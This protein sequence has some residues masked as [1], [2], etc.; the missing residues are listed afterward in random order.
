MR[1]VV[2]C[3]ALLFGGCVQSGLVPCESKAC[4]T[5]KVCAT[6]DAEPTCVYPEQ[7][8]DCTGKADGEPCTIR[9]TLVSSC[10]AAICQP[11]ECGNSVRTADEACDDGNNANGDGCSADCTSDESCGNGKTDLAAS[12]QCDDGN[13]DDSDDCRNTCVLP[14]CGD[15]ALDPLEE[16]EPA[17]DVAKA[18]GDFGYYGGTLGCSTSCRFDPAA[19]CVGRCGDAIVQTSNGEQCDGST[20]RQACLDMGADYGAA[21]CTASCSVANC[22]RFGWTHLV[23]TGG[24]F[25]FTGDNGH[26]AYV[27]G[28]SQVAYETATGWNMHAATTAYF[29]FLDQR[30][31]DLLVATD[32]EVERYLNGTWAKLPALLI[33]PSEPIKAV[34]FADDGTPTVLVSTGYTGRVLQYIGSAWTSTSLAVGGSLLDA[35]AAGKF[36]VA[37]DNGSVEY[38]A[39]GITRSVPITGTVVGL[40]IH[41]DVELAVY[42]AAGT[43]ISETRASITG[44]STNLGVRLEGYAG[45]RIVVADAHVYALDNGKLLRGTGR[46]TEVITGPT[47]QSPLSQVLVATRDGRVLVEAANSLWKL[48]SLAPTL[49]TLPMANVFDSDLRFGLTTD[50]AWLLCDTEVWI[51]GSAFAKISTTPSLRCYGIVGTSKSD[52]YVE[53]ESSSLENRLYHFNGSGWTEELYNGVRIDARLLALDSALYVVLS[54]GFIPGADTLIKSGGVWAPGPSLPAG[55][56]ASAL[57]AGAGQVYISGVCSNT[58]RMWHLSAGAWVEDTDLA[59]PMSPYG[60]YS[61]I[62]I[63]EDGS[64]FAGSGR[65]AAY[66]GGAWHF[67]TGLGIGRRVA[68]ISATDAFAGGGGTGAP[69][70][71][72]DGTDWSPIRV[73]PTFSVSW[74]VATKHDV[75]VIGMMPSTRSTWVGYSRE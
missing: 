74:L 71:H 55:C 6:V 16:C 42:T 12:E 8:S 56:A 54:N 34:M 51:A 15:G 18:C 27:S 32:A 67:F 14:R 44:T 40:A 9:N 73:D 26:L 23:T 72:F 25:A 59:Q 29:Q 63:G 49:R 43:T 60:A 22:E 39:G 41:D 65:L 13:T 28:G 58:A 4:P 57:A 69:I 64:V 21:R 75:G 53:R 2:L 70:W 19:T 52:I 30:G 31:D 24:S 38:H 45:G 47:D 61:S 11:V 50:G 66:Y 46:H 62:S 37:L 36:A 1:R 10:I 35:Y 17:L 20:A 68:A 48:S 3:V 33:N 5:D 7:L